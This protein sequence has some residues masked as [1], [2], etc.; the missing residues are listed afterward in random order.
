MA[1]SPNDCSPEPHKEIVLLRV[2]GGEKRDSHSAKILHFP[3][4][5]RRSREHLAWMY[6]TTPRIGNLYS[7]FMSTTLSYNGHLFQNGL[8]IGINPRPAIRKYESCILQLGTIQAMPRIGSSTLSPRPSL[9]PWT[10]Q[11][12]LREEMS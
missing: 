4:A 10:L 2:G 11:H 12:R 8:Q 1:E 3:A 6:C 7:S 9:G 5:F